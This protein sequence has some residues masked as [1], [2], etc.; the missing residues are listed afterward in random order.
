MTTPT[1]TEGGDSLMN[2]PTPLTKID[3]AFLRKYSEM[4][5][6]L[7]PLDLLI[8]SHAHH[9]AQ[10]EKALGR[11]ARLENALGEF[12]QQKLTTEMSAEDYEMGD[13]DFAYDKFIEMSRALLHPD[14]TKKS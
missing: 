2:I 1:L 8:E 4:K 5:G 13:I 3:I 12:S 7:E 14:S 6:G 10:L 9:S 11:I